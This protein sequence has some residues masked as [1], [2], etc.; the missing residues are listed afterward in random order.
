MSEDF[1]VRRL[2]QAE[3]EGNEL[4]V[5]IL[6]A[7]LKAGERSGAVGDER[8]NAKGVNMAILNDWNGPTEER[9]DEDRWTDDGGSRDEAD[10]NPLESSDLTPSPQNG[11]LEQTEDLSDVH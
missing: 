3:R 10:E 9:S 5:A 11:K 2:E 6:R 7:Q 8:N 1:L 4:L